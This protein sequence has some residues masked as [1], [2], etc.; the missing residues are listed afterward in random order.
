MVKLYREDS[1][2]KSAINAGLREALSDYAPIKRGGIPKEGIK[3]NTR[4]P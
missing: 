4:T 2:R 3:Q 1:A